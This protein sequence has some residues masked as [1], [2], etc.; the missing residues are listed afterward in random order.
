MY[1]VLEACIAKPPGKKEDG[2]KMPGKGMFNLY[3]A[4]TVH[5]IVYCKLYQSF[6]TP[7]LLTSK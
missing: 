5:F 1:L 2:K 4:T 6:V 7:L 3:A